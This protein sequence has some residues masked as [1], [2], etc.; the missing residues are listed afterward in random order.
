MLLINHADINV[1]D[2]R[3]ARPL[4]RAASQGKTAV[5][6]ILLD[7]GNQLQIDAKDIYGNTALSVVF[8]LFN[9][10]F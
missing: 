8:I 5:V 10:I 7:F 1:A 2:K 6:K 3:G 9:T 4:H